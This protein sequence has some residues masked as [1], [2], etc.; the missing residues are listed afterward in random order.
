MPDMK[1]LGREIQIT[2]GKLRSTEDA[3][4]AARRRNHELAQAD[5]EA[6]TAQTSSALRLRF[7]YG[8]PS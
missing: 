5:A 2:K 1:E 4:L 8:W 6:R 7:V 3:I